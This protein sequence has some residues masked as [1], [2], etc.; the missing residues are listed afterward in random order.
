MYISCWSGNRAAGGHTF[1]RR[2]TF[3]KPLRHS[4]NTLQH[5]TTHIK[6][7]CTAAGGHTLGR[8]LPRLLHTAT[9]LYRCNTLQHTATH[10][11]TLQHISN[12]DVPARVESE[13]LVATHL[14]D[15]C[16]GIQLCGAAG[17]SAFDVC[18]SVLQ[19]VAVCC[20]VLKMFAEASNSA[21]QL[22]H[23]HLMCVAVCC[24]VLQCV[25]DVCRGIQLCGAAGT[26]AFDVRCSV[27]QCVAV[28][29]SVLQ[30]VAV[31]CSVLQCVAVC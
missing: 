13:L 25:K 14:A 5:I 15:V 7:K 16:R 21:A 10:C 11:N 12:T 9:H 8:R 4:A 6:N 1:V 30:C 24:S 20:S 28:C 26:S 31:C 3:A 17:T 23:L 2:Q 27:L 19:C 18:C 29:C 22:V